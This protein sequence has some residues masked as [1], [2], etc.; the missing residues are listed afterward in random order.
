MR[1]LVIVKPKMYRE[2]LALAL[3]E[4]RPDAEVMI[5]PADSLDGHMDR[6]NPDLLVRNDN[7]GLSPKYLDAIA[8]QIEILLTDGMGARINLD[9]RI[10]EME[11]ICIDD[12]LTVLDEVEELSSAE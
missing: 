9:G 12:L 11:D 2:T 7:D 10:Q 5:A 8:C 3:H 4:H 6:F 1:V